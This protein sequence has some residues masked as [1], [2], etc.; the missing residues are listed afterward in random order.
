MCYFR[1]LSWNTFPCRTLQTITEQRLTRLTTQFVIGYRIS[2]LKKPDLKYSL[3]LHKISRDS[4]KRVNCRF[5]FHI[6]VGNTHNEPLSFLK[7]FSLSDKVLC[8][9]TSNPIW[10]LSHVLVPMVPIR[11]FTVRSRLKIF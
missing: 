9:N 1:G 3:E 11:I 5:P 10:R 4:D 6:T 7:A 2:V 8:R